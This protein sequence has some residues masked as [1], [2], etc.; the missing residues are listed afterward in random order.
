[1]NIKSRFRVRDVC[2]NLM[3]YGIAKLERRSA[4]LKMIGVVVTDITA[5][6]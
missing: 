4:S 2:I 6:A 3:K 5:P 1:M